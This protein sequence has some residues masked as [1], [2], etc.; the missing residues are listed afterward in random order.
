[1]KVSLFQGILMGVFVL[2]AA[3]G[4]FVFATYTSKNTAN[5]IGPVLVWGTLPEKT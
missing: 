2:G 3:V 4:L 1:M 5:T